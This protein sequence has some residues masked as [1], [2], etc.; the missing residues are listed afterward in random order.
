MNVARAPNKQ[1]E[2]SYG[3]TC[4]PHVRHFIMRTR[5]V[6]HVATPPLNCGVRRIFICKLH[7]SQPFF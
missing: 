6:G 3:V 7:A 4:A 1:L 5:R 2:R